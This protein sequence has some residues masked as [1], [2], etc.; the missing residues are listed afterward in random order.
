MKM[1]C[2]GKNSRIYE[3]EGYIVFEGRKDENHEFEITKRILKTDPS[4]QAL[5]EMTTPRNPQ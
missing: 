5:V 3:S 1:L 2:N 4:V